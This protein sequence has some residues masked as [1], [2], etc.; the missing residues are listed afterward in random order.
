M[1]GS[2]SAGGTGLP[3]GSWACRSQA[4]PARGP[5]PPLGARPLGAIFEPGAG[6]SLPPRLPAGGAAPAPSRH[7]WGGRILK[8]VLPVAPAWK[9]HLP[10][11]PGSGRGRLDQFKNGA[12]SLTAPGLPLWRR[13]GEGRGG[14]R[15]RE[16]AGPWP[17]QPARSP[18]RPVWRE[19]RGPGRW[20]QAGLRAPRGPGGRGRCGT[21]PWAPCPCPRSGGASRASAGRR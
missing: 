7:P 20:R 16:R 3:R 6:D 5:R 9:N 14:V 15:R 11:F 17:W 4:A 1:P 8:L 2:G 18:G 21:R 10:P 19:A 12:G 13:G